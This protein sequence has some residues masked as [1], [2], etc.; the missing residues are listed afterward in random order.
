[1]FSDKEI[2]DIRSRINSDEKSVFIDLMKDII[3]PNIST[4]S[5]FENFFKYDSRPVF[6]KIGVMDFF[7]IYLN[8][9][10][11][12]EDVE[13]PIHDF[14]ED[15]NKKKI[16]YGLESFVFFEL[17]L[18]KN[19][20]DIS[21]Y[22]QDML[23]YVIQSNMPKPFDYICKNYSVELNHEHLL[24]A[25]D[26]INLIFKPIKKNF[27]TQPNIWTEITDENHNNVLHR[28]VMSQNR[29]SSF[30]DFQC[31][32]E[33]ISP[34]SLSFLTNQ[35]NR[36]GNTPFTALLFYIH[37]VNEKIVNHN[38]TMSDAMASNFVNWLVFFKYTPDLN[39]SI[40]H[41]NNNNESPYDLLSGY[42][43]SVYDQND[44]KLNSLLSSLIIEQEKAKIAKNLVEKISSKGHNNR[45]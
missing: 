18:K 22:I 17:L 41:K 21:P 32:I 5:D 33:G 31:A 24:E 26:G 23:T 8:S 45:I 10:F 19:E 14:I 39:N 15:L 16:I 35:V 20:I 43:F 34:Q 1:M 25:A 29:F 2:Q 28:L 13:E 27:I 42:N 12:E 37:K 9:I 7:K 6:D 30:I 44:N 40:F 11:I 3:L 38:S 36:D 4:K